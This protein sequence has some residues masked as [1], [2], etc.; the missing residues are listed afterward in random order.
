MGIVPLLH[1]LRELCGERP[2]GERP[3][4]ERPLRA[5]FVIDDP[6]LHRS[7]YGYL[8]YGELIAH[9]GAHGYHAGLAMV[10][11]DA[12]LVSRHAAELVKANPAAISLLVHGNDH[13]A[14]ELG[15]LSRAR[16]ADLALAQALR[17]I[18][19]F[20]SRSGVAVGRVMAP[21]HGACSLPALEAMFRLGFDGACISRP[22][23]WRDGLA[24]LSPLVGWD[25]AEMVAGGLPILP[26]Y[27]LDRSREDLIFRALLGQPLILYGHHWDFSEGL[28]V[29]ARAA[30]DVNRLGDVAWGPARAIAVNRH[31][32]RRRGET[33]EVHMHSRST[34]V[35]IPNGV[36]ALVVHSGQAHGDAPPLLSVAGGP[37][38]PL[39]RA[40]FG[41]SSSAMEVAPLRRVRLSLV[42]DRALDPGALPSLAPRP[43]AI[44][45]RALVECRDRGRP[46]LAGR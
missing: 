17:R 12:W 42:P 20:E 6:N 14:R 15:R 44:A 2:G 11:L 25:P 3:G 10:P 37:P 45:R 43:W 26:R 34:V 36:S 5:S 8:D 39:A 24:P 46:L 16:D 7:S 30:D 18:A 28:D 38:Q 13:V 32:A 41:W 27:P 21:P 9:A 29:L 31:Q 23:P 4:G 1:F 33:L 35:E 22:H 40:G 19:G